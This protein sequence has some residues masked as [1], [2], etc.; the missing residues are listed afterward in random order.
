MA[1]RDAML[2][3][4]GSNT[5]DIF[6]HVGDMAYSSG[7]TLEFTTN[8]FAIYQPI[9]RNTVVWPAM[10]NHEGAS[11]DSGT[12]TGPYYDA[13]VLP[14]GTQAGGLASLPPLSNGERGQDRARGGPDPSGS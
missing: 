13:Y 12:Q 10:G 3:D 1:V 4:V 5:P 8:F 14:T 7:T 11:S 2:T 9:L 6:V